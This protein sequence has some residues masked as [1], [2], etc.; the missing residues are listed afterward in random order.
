MTENYTNPVLKSGNKRNKS[1]IYT[2]FSKQACAPFLRHA[3][4]IKV[5]EEDWGVSFDR[6]LICLERWYQSCI[7]GEPA[8]V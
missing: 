5:M 2:A 3:V 1:P 6:P 7:S 8:F 4:S